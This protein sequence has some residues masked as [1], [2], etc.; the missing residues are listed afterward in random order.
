M[1][2]IVWAGLAVAMTSTA[3]L[4]TAPATAQTALQWKCTGN[5][6]LAWDV[7]IE[8]CTTAIR[9]GK[10]SGRDLAWAYCNRG[11]AHH[12]KGDTDR[13]ITDYNEA[14]RLDPKFA[15]AY[16]N[17]GSAYHDKGDTDRAITDYNEAI[18]LDPKLAFAY[19]NRG[20]A[21]H[22]KGDP[23]RAITDYNEAIRLDP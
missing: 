8:G 5:P 19:N 15:F 4:V 16:N 11:N 23:D 14:I 21:Y 7:Q 3:T 12:D 18:R 13:A 10:Y 22:D 1:R 9:S 2:G 17:R 6:D 20:S